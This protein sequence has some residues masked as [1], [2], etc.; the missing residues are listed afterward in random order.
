MCPD[1]PVL[2]NGKVT[3]STDTVAPFSLTTMA[4]Y[5][6]DQGYGLSGGNTIRTCDPNADNTNREG[7]WSEDAPTC[8]GE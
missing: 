3:F 4:T 1:L 6:C 7:V 5:S 8:E 2:T